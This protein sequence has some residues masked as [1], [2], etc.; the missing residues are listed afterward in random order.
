MEIKYLIKEA[1]SNAVDHGFHDCYNIAVNQATM[2]KVNN[3]NNDYEK[4]VVTNILSSYMNLLTSEI[5]EA[6]QEL[7][8]D[9]I[10]ALLEELADVYIRLSDLV[11][12]LGYADDME[13]VIQKKLYKN[14]KR[15]YK[16][17]KLI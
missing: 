1:Y 16:H 9:N 12:V 3:E 10:S 6:T 4:E 8:K 5:G 13:E 17:G 11:G 15:P 14:R 2:K 7:R